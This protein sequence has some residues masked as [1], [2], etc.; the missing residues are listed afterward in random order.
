MTL[1]HAQGSNTTWSARP[2]F[3][4]WMFI[5]FH[6]PLFNLTTCTFAFLVDNR[7]MFVLGTER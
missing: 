4:L 3:L 5:L 2:W 1:A 6:V 7:A